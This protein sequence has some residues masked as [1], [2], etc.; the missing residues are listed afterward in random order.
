V[1]SIIFVNWNSGQQLKDCIRSITNEKVNSAIEIIIVDNFSSDNSIDLLMELD[2]NG[3][4]LKIIYNKSNNG[5]GLA[6]NQGA[7]LASG[8][9]LLFLNTDTLLSEEALT[10]PIQFLNDKENADIGIVGVQL[11]DENNTISRSCAKFPT[12]SMFFVN[13]LGLN[14]ISVFKNLDYHMLGWNHAENKVVDHVIGAFFFVRHTLFKSI[15][16]F[17]ERFFVYL[18]DLDFSLRARDSG[19]KTMFLANTSVFHRGGGTSSQVKAHRMF[20]ALRSKLLYGFKHLSKLEAWI[21]F[22]SV[23]TIELIMRLILSILR[24]SWKDCLNTLYA[25][26]MLYSDALNILKIA[27][28][29]IIIKLKNENLS[30]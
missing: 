23:L 24:L 27:Y 14:R 5:F 28:K 21:L 11:I 13:I 2:L 12:L 9:Y 17:D 6:C 8:D 29:K 30:P 4:N 25:Y 3:I 7:K 15:G 19:W 26:K 10:N 22:F 1:V 16:G 20:Y 18:E